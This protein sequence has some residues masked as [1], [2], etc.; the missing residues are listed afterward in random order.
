MTFKA[1]KH[2]ELNSFLFLRNNETFVFILNANNMNTLTLV[3]SIIT[4]FISFCKSVYVIHLKVFL[5]S[6]SIT[7]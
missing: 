4:P 2:Y 7:A 1:V 3:S 5:K 6:F